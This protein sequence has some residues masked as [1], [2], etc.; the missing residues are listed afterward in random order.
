MPYPR[1]EGIQNTCA[2]IEVEGDADDWQQPQHTV[3]QA[4]ATVQPLLWWLFL[5][6]RLQ[7]EVENVDG[8]HGDAVQ[9]ERLE[10]V[11]ADLCIAARTTAS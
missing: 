7:K 6:K 1:K 11:S 3:E 2:H 5:H 8:E 9:N 4:D 10:R